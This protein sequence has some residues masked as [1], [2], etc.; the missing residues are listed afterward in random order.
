MSIAIPYSF[1]LTAKRALIFCYVLK[2]FLSQCF[3]HLS[4]MD[5]FFLRDDPTKKAPL[6]GFVFLIRNNSAYRIGSPSPYYAQ[7]KL[8][9]IV[10][11]IVLPT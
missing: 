10:H 3:L 5:I 9:K 7:Y 4:L 6:I 2:F 8:F 11:F 1:S